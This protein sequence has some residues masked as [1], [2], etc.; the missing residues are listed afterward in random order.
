MWR[1]YVRTHTSKS[2]QPPQVNSPTGKVFDA[3][4][5]HVLVVVIAELG[6]V[7][8]VRV[9]V[10]R[11]R[12]GA[13]RSNLVQSAPGLTFVRHLGIVGEQRRHTVGV[14]LGVGLEVLGIFGID[15][16]SRLTACRHDG[17]HAGSSCGPRLTPR[18]NVRV[19]GGHDAIECRLCVSMRFSSTR[20]LD[21]VSDEISQLH[22]RTCVGCNEVQRVDD[23]PELT[24][25]HLAAYPLLEVGDHPNRT[26][27]L[28]LRFV[29]DQNLPLRSEHVHLLQ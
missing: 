17:L 26:E 3:T 15:P 5:G 4:D 22:T 28:F 18:P 6:L 9:A 12:T 13:P 8:L 24:T 7:D 19:D 29:S 20:S 23:C 27:L 1:G 11:E 25:R 10:L 14:A 16:P 2:E 21:C